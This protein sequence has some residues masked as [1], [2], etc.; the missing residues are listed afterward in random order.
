MSSLTPCGRDVE[1]VEG[2]VE[3]GVERVS[4]AVSRVSRLD[5]LD[6]LLRLS[7]EAV[8]VCDTQDLDFSILEMS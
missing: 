1:G 2:D 5:T 4:R 6:T 7:H 3:G 8:V